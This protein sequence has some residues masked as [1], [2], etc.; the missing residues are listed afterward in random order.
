LLETAPQQLP[1]KSAPIGT[2]RVLESST[3]H[4]IIEAQT[5]TPAI[6][7]IT[8]SYSRDWRAWGLPD[9][10]GKESAQQE[11]SVQPANW[12]LRAIPLQAGKHKIRLEYLPRIF[13]IGKWVSLVSLACFLL[14]ITLAFH[15]SNEPR[16]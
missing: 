16:A 7:L 4:M 12:V 1:K 14:A 15:K 2:A 13:V 11:Y 8:D 9:E 10:N 6:L 3:D 5:K